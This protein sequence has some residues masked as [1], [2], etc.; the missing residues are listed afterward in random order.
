MRMTI[1]VEFYLRCEKRSSICYFSFRI[2]TLAS[3]FVALP[4]G[5]RVDLITA[6]P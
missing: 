2:R 6:A 5:I 3:I 1:T 4:I